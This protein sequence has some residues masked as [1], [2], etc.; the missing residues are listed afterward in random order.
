M[1]KP[2]QRDYQQKAIRKIELTQGQFALVDGWNYEKLSKY[3]WYAAWRKTSQSFYAIRS[4]WKDGKTHLILMHREILGLKEG[5]KRQADHINHNTLNNCEE[6]LRIVNHQQN[7]FNQ[8]NP[9][10]Y[11][12]YK[13]LRKYKAQI[14]IDGKQK[15]LGYFDN[16]KKARK[17][18]L[19]AKRKCHKI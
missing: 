18:Y 1:T 6:N 14:M 10:G 2:K 17:A 13:P 16:P 19:K 9:K 5:D 4:E 3:K 7:Q 11:T 15:H 12:W 8:K